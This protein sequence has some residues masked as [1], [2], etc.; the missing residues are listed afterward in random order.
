MKQV[1]LADNIRFEKY[2]QTTKRTA[3]LSPIGEFVVRSLPSK[4]IDRQ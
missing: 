2:G 3:S 1:T 4:L